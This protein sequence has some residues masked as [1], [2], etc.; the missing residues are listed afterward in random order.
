MEEET[1]ITGTETPE[2]A[3]GL[4]EEVGNRIENEATNEEVHG[5]GIEDVPGEHFGEEVGGEHIEGETVEGEGEHKEQVLGEGEELMGE[6]LEGEQGEEKVEG[7]EKQEEQPVKEEQVEEEEAYVEEPPPD[8]A[9]PYDLSDSK[10]AL[11][12]PFQLRP[13]Q[14]AEV[15]QLWEFYQNYTPAYTDINGYIT[16]KELVYMLKC[17][18]VMTYTEEQLHQLIAFCVRPPHPE[19]HITYEQFLKMVILRQRDFPAEEELRSALQVFDPGRTGTVDREY[20][21][22]VLAKQ[23]HKLPQKLVDNLIKEVDITNDGTIGVE[24]VVGTMCIDL[25]T[26]DIMMLRAAVYTEEDQ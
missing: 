25:N 9:A 19:G 26:D 4:E 5:E 3:V 16:E 21:K 10:E 7:E 17:L 22:E 12:T 14:L 23:G 8:P 13:D 2:T 11:K 18:L 20:L 1:T 24:D 15:E 6:A